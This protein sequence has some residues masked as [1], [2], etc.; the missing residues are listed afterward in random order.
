MQLQSR[1]Q[2]PRRSLKMG[3]KGWLPPTATRSRLRETTCFS[4][5]GSCT[6]NYS[7]GTQ[8]NPIVAIPSTNGTQPFTFPTQ[9]TARLPSDLCV[10]RADQSGP[11]SLAFGPS[12][13]GVDQYSMVVVG[14]H[15]FVFA[16]CDLVVEIQRMVAP[17]PTFQRQ[18]RLLAP[19]VPTQIVI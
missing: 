2:Q 15:F 6:C 10:S 11:Q 4:S 5:N 1:P 19:K 13:N 3:T 7:N 9:R 18:R 12:G 8:W 14:K 17:L 16:C